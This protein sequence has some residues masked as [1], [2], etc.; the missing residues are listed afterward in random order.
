MIKKLL[1]EVKINKIAIAQIE[2]DIDD[3]EG[4][5]ARRQEAIAKATAD[6]AAFVLIGGEAGRYEDDK[7]LFVTD[8]ATFKRDARIDRLAKLAIE[9]KSAGKLLVYASA[10][11]ICDGG[12]AI[13]LYDGGSVVVTP[14][15]KYLELFPSR[16]EEGFVTIDLD[17]LPALSPI[18]TKEDFDIT[19][20]AVVN[21]VRG[22][23]NKLNLTRVVVGVS[24]GID[25]AVTAALYG[26]ILPPEDLLL[27]GMPGPFT[28]QTTRN[29]GQELA[30]NLG[31]RF[32]EIPIKESVD[33]TCRQFSEL[34]SKGPG[35]GV[36]GAWE[37]SSFAIENVQARD[38]GARILAA[39]AAVFGGVIS[40]NANKDEITIGYGTQYGDII[41]WLAPLGDLWKGDVYA[42]GR[43]LND[44]VY[45]R[46]VIP[47]EIFTIRPSAELS[48][49]QCIEKGLGDP[50]N[51]PYHDKLLRYWVE[52]GATPDD[53]IRRYLD[54]SLADVI[55][56]EGKIEELY[57]NR[58]VFQA[59]IARWWNLYKGLAVAKRLQA[60]PILALSKKSF[61]EFLERQSSRRWQP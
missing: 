1:D 40:C 27:V 25:S 44:K 35:G 49:N 61:G 36:A 53:C 56:F 10:V 31:A 20:E 23:L 34:I 4:T 18:P 55:D 52:D 9:A 33:L 14:E 22:F 8:D 29:L 39:A 5:E 26:S 12:K 37:L 3:L 46:E 60:P 54:G 7:Y 57:P 24:G 21:G 15:G 38:R 32:F 51:Y 2:I 28:S 58:E 50:L 42:L 13:R 19:A 16:F 43:Y 30:K 48:A 41:G 6:G 59:D 47:E 11:G 45:K 17:S